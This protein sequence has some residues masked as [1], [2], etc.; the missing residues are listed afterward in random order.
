MLQTSPV[1]LQIPGGQIQGS[2]IVHGGAEGGVDDQGSEERILDGVDV[3]DQESTE[4]RAIDCH[5]PDR[6]EQRERIA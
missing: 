6:A 3:D 4:I 2:N 5:G 1:L